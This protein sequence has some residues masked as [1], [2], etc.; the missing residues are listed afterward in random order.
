MLSSRRNDTKYCVRSNISEPSGWKYCQ[1]N[2]AA[3]WANA[4]T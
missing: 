2:H 1:A 3:A 4:A